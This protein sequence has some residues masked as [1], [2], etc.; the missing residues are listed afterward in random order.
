M[1]IYYNDTLNYT[2]NIKHIKTIVTICVLCNYT[3]NNE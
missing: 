3:I 2:S 1:T